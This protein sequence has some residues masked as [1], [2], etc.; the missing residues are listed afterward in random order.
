MQYGTRCC[1]LQL[2]ICNRGIAPLGMLHPV[3]VELKRIFL[4]TEGDPVEYG[5]RSCLFQLYICNRGIAPLDML[6]LVLV[7]SKRFF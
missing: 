6:K 7:E 1:L 5:M 3:L 2:Y 4:L